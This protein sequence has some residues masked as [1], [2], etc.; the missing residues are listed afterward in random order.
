MK[1]ASILN[2]IRYHS[3]K[4]DDGFRAE[5]C[6][7]AREF[8]RTGDT[9][10]AAYI[11]S[12]I[13]T[14]DSM[15][16]QDLDVRSPF[17]EK[18]DGDLEPLLLPDVV[19]KDIVGVVNA[20]NHHAGIGKFLFV[21]APG[22]GKTEAVRQLARLLKCDLYA[23]N[24]AALIDSRLGQTA[25]NIDS[26]FRDI[27]R[28]A[29]TGKAVV[30]FDELDGIALD[31]VDSNDM[32]EMGRATTEVLKGLDSVPSGAVLVATTN[33][34]HRFDRALKRRFDFIV[35]F[36]RYS[37][38]DIV[39]IAERMLNR[40]FDKMKLGVRDVRLFRK[41][42]G[43][44][45]TMPSPGE[46]KNVIRTAVAF[47]DPD[48][49]SDYLRRLFASVKG[50]REY[51]PRELNERGFTVREIGVLTQRSKSGVGRLLSLDKEIRT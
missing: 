1:K 33:L 38:E 40:F 35:D 5:A 37:R 47:S 15:L 25:R 4:N 51:S 43:L 23:V 44:Y 10:L 22:T 39:G 13:S 17:L 2:L 42:I 29:Q 46:L 12:M 8:D 24:V 20:V 16:P 27:G 6:E 7:I 3:E 21:G 30:L 9:Q 14:Q 19:T 31:R 45:E 36:D 41:I 28:L 11:M 49:G 48:D 34:L 18:V 32:R 50:G 26:L